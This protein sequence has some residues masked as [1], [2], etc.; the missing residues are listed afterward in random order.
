MK[1]LNRRPEIYNIY[2]NMYIIARYLYRLQD[3]QEYTV[4]PWQGSRILFHLSVNSVIHS[5]S[6]SGLGFIYVSE[7]CN[8]VCSIVGSLDC[9]HVI[10]YFYLICPLTR[11]R[12]Y[13]ANQKRLRGWI[14][15]PGFLPP[16]PNFSKIFLMGMFLG[17]RNPTAIIKKFYLHCMTLK[18]KVKKGCKYEKKLILVLILTFSRLRISKMLKKLRDLDS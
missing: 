17:S 8:R 9:A 13:F 4:A 10:S 7:A 18:I 16:R 6:H 2:I 5:F 12:R 3:V 15:P 14:P 11:R 1:K